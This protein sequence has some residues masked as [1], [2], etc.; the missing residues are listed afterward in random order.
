MLFD[1]WKYCPLNC[2]CCETKNETKNETYKEKMARLRPAKIKILKRH[3][4]VY[5]Y[6][7]ENYYADRCLTII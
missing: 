5:R 3:L 7:L 6:H 4:R 2:S 1:C